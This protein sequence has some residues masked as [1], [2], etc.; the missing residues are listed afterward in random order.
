MKTQE[1]IIEK[2]VEMANKTN[3]TYGCDAEELLDIYLRK[4]L[5]LQAKQIFEEI[6]RRIED[7]IIFIRDI[8][9]IKKKYLGDGK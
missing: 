9:A 6:E 8:D 4:A 1:E 7:D 3:N 2:I 5:E